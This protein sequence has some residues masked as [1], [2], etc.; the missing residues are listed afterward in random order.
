MP[1][2]L[3]LEQV[4]D[5]MRK[6]YH[7]YRKAYDNSVRTQA[8]MVLLKHTPTD[9]DIKE[10]IQSTTDPDQTEHSMYIQQRLFL[11]ASRNEELK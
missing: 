8:L 2:A 7:Q 6:I 10:I 5:V 1:C 11:L 3:P 4:K 9:G